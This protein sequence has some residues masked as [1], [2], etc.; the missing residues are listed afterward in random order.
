MR[1]FPDVELV[2]VSGP[3]D[4][5]CWTHQEKY[6]SRTSMVETVGG[7]N[8]SKTVNELEGLL[9]S[10]NFE[11]TVL[12]GGGLGNYAVQE[13]EGREEVMS[14]VLTGPLESIPY[15]PERFYSLASRVWRKP[16]IM[17]KLFF[18][19][20][21]DY[22]VVRE[23]SGLKTPDYRD[24]ESFNLGGLEVPLKNSLVMC[25]RNCRFSRMGSVERLKPNSEVAF[26]N[27]GTFSFFERPQEFNKAL[28]DYLRN[29]DSI[30]ERRET[31]KAVSKNRSLKEF[32]DS[33]VVER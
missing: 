15:M 7:Q 26:L 9:D 28:A 33:L 10:S 14:T 6:F 11:H 31:L 19:P 4:S 20:A 22:R 29:K 2:F 12:V 16:K 27:A 17:K 21:T 13:L 5:G 25:N 32:E 30:L 8:F 1:E 23:F 3:L 24:L 18:S